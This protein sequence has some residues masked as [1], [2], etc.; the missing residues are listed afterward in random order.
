M[1]LRSG[2]SYSTT[3][4]DSSD[5]DLVA[6]VLLPDPDITV[7]SSSATHYFDLD[8]HMEQ[9]NLS[10]NKQ[11]TIMT[12]SA[13]SPALHAF[14]KNP[15]KYTSSVPCLKSDGSNFYDWSQAIDGVLMYI[16]HRMSFTDTIDTFDAPVEV[17]GTLR[18]FIQPTISPNLTEIIQQTFSPKDAY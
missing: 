18:F 11:N 9:S 1:P 16:F 2:K 13:V 4:S 8:S 17:M 14:I 3:K 7:Q 12:S 6:S 15:S 10:E 5:S